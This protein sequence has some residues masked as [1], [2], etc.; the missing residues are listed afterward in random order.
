MTTFS[1]ACINGLKC[2]NGRHFTSRAIHKMHIV[3][4]K[5]TKHYTK[6]EEIDK[7]SQ[8]IYMNQIVKKET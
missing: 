7:N 6:E 1:I 4:P 5:S 3:L 2:D 8:R